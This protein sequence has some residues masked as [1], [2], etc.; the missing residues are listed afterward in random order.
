V[1]ARLAADGRSEESAKLRNAEL[2]VL[3]DGWRQHRDG[4][5][6][7]GSP[8][9]NKRLLWTPAISMPRWASRATL[10]V[11][12]VRIEPLQAIRRDHVRAEGLLPVCGGLLWRWPPPVRGLWRDPR[13][14]FAAMWDRHHATP[15]TRWSDAPTVIVLQVRLER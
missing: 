7:A 8:P 5:G 3:A 10:T 11:E 6:R 13:R 9:T 14:A 15:G 4:T 1:A 2:V 12:A